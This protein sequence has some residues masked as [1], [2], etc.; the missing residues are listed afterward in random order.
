MKERKPIT[1]LAIVLKT[2]ATCLVIL[3][4]V[5]CS[6]RAES[7]HYIVRGEDVL[8]TKL[9][10]PRGIVVQPYSTEQ[11]I[12][13]TDQGVNPALPT[14]ILHARIL[15]TR[16]DE[17]VPE[18]VDR[19]E[20]P[21]SPVTKPGQVLLE[22]YTG[23]GPT[24]IRNAVFADADAGIF[25]THS[26][27][28]AVFI[29]DVDYD[30]I[31]NPPTMFFSADPSVFSNIN[32]IAKSRQKV[33]ADPAIYLAD[34][35]EYLTPTGTPTPVEGK[36]HKKPYN[37]L[38]T[39]EWTL[40]SPILRQPWSLAYSE[41]SAV[42]D[43]RLY[44]VDKG[45]DGD[46]AAIYAINPMMTP[47]PLATMNPDSPH[48][49][50]L[51]YTPTAGDQRLQV[52]VPPGDFY[53]IAGI[54][55]SRDGNTIWFSAAKNKPGS[56][57]YRTIYK[58]MAFPGF[59]PVELDGMGDGEKHHPEHLWVDHELGPDL[60]Y[61]IFATDAARSNVTPAIYYLDAE[62][63]QTIP[64]PYTPTYA[65]EDLVPGTPSPG[66]TP[67]STVTTTPTVTATP[68]P[69]GDEDMLFGDS[70]FGVIDDYDDRDGVRI[71]AIA[72]MRVSI[73]VRP[74]MLHVADEDLRFQW[75]RP[76][77]ELRD[78]DGQVLFAFGD[79]VT[80]GRFRVRNFILQKTGVYALRVSGLGRGIGALGGYHIYL[81]GSTPN[82][83][84]SMEDSANPVPTIVIPAIAT[85]NFGASFTR[86]SGDVE[87]VIQVLD[88]NGDK[89]IKED[90]D[91]RT[92][93]VGFETEI[94][95][96]HTIDPSI[97]EGTGNYRI[98]WNIT[99]PPGRR[100]LFEE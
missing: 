62:Y 85:G 75:L 49:G 40:S 13:V 5:C 82:V 33:S 16:L 74:T 47:V 77:V 15:G 27:G 50:E 3:L 23:G 34:S 54:A 32:G 18:L 88:P 58:M 66:V 7:I 46:G 93:F 30:P 99:N 84:G 25:G 35:P 71:H 76:V 44:I 21:L 63:V 8:G 38:P 55:V 22:F 60:Y 73:F 81:R 69:Y 72:G 90:P 87:G 9:L 59:T 12:V 4:G 61:R 68:E 29:L 52:I 2:L 96:N 80:R 37:N 20:G 28:S 83:S 6:V 41:V 11:W 45:K 14:P 42:Q 79:A 65:S 97:S 43:R 70:Y 31:N 19:T 39:V 51:D 48:I 57:S 36:I 89:M 98:N 86:L 10:D 53:E 94:S 26:V 78:P 100:I 17:T 64:P 56:R 1:C 92:A 24:D 91:E 95:G 67:P